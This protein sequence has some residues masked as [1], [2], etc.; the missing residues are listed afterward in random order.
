[1]GDI[2]RHAGEGDPRTELADSFRDFMIQAIKQQETQEIEALRA[3]TKRLPA[4]YLYK[5]DGGFLKVL[6]AEP[7]DDEVLHE[8]VLMD[9]QSRPESSLPNIWVSVV[10]PPEAYNARPQTED[11]VEENAGTLE[12][13]VFSA[14]NLFIRRV[15]RDGRVERKVS[16]DEKYVPEVTNFDTVEAL[17]G[18]TLP[19]NEE[20]IV[21]AIDVLQGLMRYDIRTIRSS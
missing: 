7:A 15:F 3:R 20:Q 8:E 11:D 4:G 17:L 5:V 21:E 13:I 16:G 14:E 1:M 9:E 2:S 19:L 6:L 12:Y 18:Y 10:V